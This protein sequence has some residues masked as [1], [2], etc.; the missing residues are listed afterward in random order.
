MWSWIHR[1]GAPKRSFFLCR[2]YRPWFGCLSFALFAFGLYEAL[3]VAPPDYQQGEVYRVLF[4]HV[5]CAVLS[6][7]CYMV[8]TLSEVFAYIW[9]LTIAGI[10]ARVLAPL[11]LLF[12]GLTLITGSLWGRPTWGT[13]WIWD[14]RLTSELILGFIYLGVIGLRSALPKTTQAQRIMAVLTCIGAVNIPI[15]H[16]SVQWWHTLH[17]G[18]TLLRWGTPQMDVSMLPAL[19]LCLGAFITFAIWWAMSECE[20]E[21][22]LL[23]RDTQWVKEWL[24]R[25]V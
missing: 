7:A 21:L 5:P 19:L 14:A 1:L 3:W 8:M 16:Y 6:L 9:S 11:G 23:K 24:E 17:Q 2:R 4:I 18:A 22:L 15:I 25:R 12:T 10:I 20:R 13:Y